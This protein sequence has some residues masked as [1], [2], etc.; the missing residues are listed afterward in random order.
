MG[1]GK[2]KH[3]VAAGNTISLSKKSNSD[4]LK[5]IQ[6][7]ADTTPEAA[8]TNG[9]NL[10]AQKE[11]E[12]EA[13]TGSGGENMKGVADVGDVTQET[14]VRAGEE[15]DGEAVTNNPSS[16]K[17]VDSSANVALAETVAPENVVEEKKEDTDNGEPKI[18][19][20]ENSAEE[21]ESAQ[22]VDESKATS[23]QGAA[24]N[25]AASDEKMN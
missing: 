14:E 19:K 2:S 13:N 3:D 18:V 25:V 15:K 24:P 20:E 9:T 4:E 5:D 17:E 1:C 16:T 12:S 8:N 7:D 22:T 21:P 11:G 10:P 6:K 23:A